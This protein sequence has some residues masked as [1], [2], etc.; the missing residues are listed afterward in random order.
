MPKTKEPLAE[1]SITCYD[2]EVTLEAPDALQVQV[3]A[4]TEGWAREQ[5]RGPKGWDWLWVCNV[6]RG[7][8]LSQLG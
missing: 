4:V 8:K 6:D 5:R 3:R 7:K 2:C 1:A